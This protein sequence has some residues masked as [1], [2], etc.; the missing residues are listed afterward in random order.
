MTVRALIFRNAVP[1]TYALVVGAAVIVDFITDRSGGA[2]VV[3]T[4][5]IALV[6]VVCFMVGQLSAKIDEK[7]FL[8]YWLI[9]AVLILLGFLCFASKGG[10]APKEGELIFTY[11]M[12]LSMPPASF[13]L[14]LIPSV[15]EGHSLNDVMLRSVVEWLACV[16]TGGIQ[17]VAV[18]WLMRNLRG[19]RAVR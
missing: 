12:L 9:G 11:A 3:A 1:C 8:S 15:S 13:V 6:A 5:P 4:L 18:R 10:D 7:R 2:F 17:W 14:P 19:R 16:A